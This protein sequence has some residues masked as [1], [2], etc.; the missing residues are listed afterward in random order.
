M[1]TP[2]IHTQLAALDQIAK[3]TAAAREALRMRR[4]RA[5]AAA[6]GEA[7]EAAPAPA[8][9]IHAPINLSTSGTHDLV[10]AVSG[11]RIAVY[12]L[13]LWNVTEQDLEL[14]DGS[15]S[16]MGPL[17]SFP[18]QFGILLHYVGEPHFRC[19]LGNALKLSLSAA[20][21]VSG[22]VLY[23]MENE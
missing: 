5:A 13:M 9:L 20:A 4:K 23:R 17:N 12:E 16:L 10:A 3:E 15:D 1:T 19:Q 18:A 2:T 6:R 8:E 14:F 21:Q 22:Y 7:E 11:M